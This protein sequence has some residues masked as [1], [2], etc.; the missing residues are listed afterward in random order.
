MTLRSSRRQF[1][2][3]STA[4]TTGVAGIGIL[5]SISCNQQ[6][7]EI[8]NPTR[9]ELIERL[10]KLAKSEPPRNLSRGAMCYQMA[11]PAIEKK[12]CP[13]C[14]H[15]MI[16]GEKNEILREYNVPLKRIQD[17]GI[18]AKLIIPEHCPECGFGLGFC[19]VTWQQQSELSPEEVQSKRFHLEIKYPD[20]QDTVNVELESAFELE[21][22]ALFLHGQD[23]YE[24]GQGR[25]NAL[26]D[27][28]DRLREL[29]GVKEKPQ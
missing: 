16:I 29:F 22:M 10:E 3:T 18:D 14:E 7:T 1:L 4:L 23:R 8:R 13:A 28:A 19:G 17:Q 9:A 2:K 26:R 24:V 12:P 5:A 11:I 25:E 20:R 15:T 6:P 27:H 21:L